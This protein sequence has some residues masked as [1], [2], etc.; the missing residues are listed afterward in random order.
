MSLSHWIRDYLFFPL[1]ASLPRAWGR[2]V[3]VVVSMVAFGAW[4][5]VGWTFL[6][7]GLYHGVLQ[8]GQR[9]LG[10]WG[11]GRGAA[12]AWRGVWTAAGWALTFA[13]VSYGWL[14]FRSASVSQAWVLTVAVLSPH[15]YASFSLRPNF[16][17]VVA[18]VA[19][20]YFT[21]GWARNTAPRLV[22]RRPI[23]AI[24]AVVRP[25]CYAAMILAIIV[26]SHQTS[27]FVYFQF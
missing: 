26:W 13:L 12:P 11:P 19:V 20:F 15:R 3:A 23:T 24:V 10:A 16:Y 7:W 2:Q 6:L 1:A 27:I 17:I 4:H 8:I 22:E 5:G 25:I 14:L 18:L 9:V 21:Y